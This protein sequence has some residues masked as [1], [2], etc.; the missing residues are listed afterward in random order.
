MN[1]R[2]VACGGSARCGPRRRRP[3]IPRGPPKLVEV[4]VRDA[5]TDADEDRT[6]A[7]RR[8][9]RRRQRRLEHRRSVPAPATGRAVGALARACAQEPTDEPNSRSDLVQLNLGLRG[10]GPVP[11]DQARGQP[12]AAGREV[13]RPR[14][15]H[16]D[17]AGGDLAPVLD[18]GRRSRRSSAC[19]RRSRP[20]PR[21]ARADPDASTTMQREPT[22]AP[23]ST[24]TGRPARAPRR[25]SRRRRTGGRPRRPGAHDPTVAHVHQGAGTDPGADVHVARHQDDAGREVRAVARGRGRHD[26]HAASPRP[27]LQ[28]QEVAVLERTDLGRLELRTRK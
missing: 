22:N 13:A 5:G 25:R 19:C 18:G 9:P 28:G 8:L 21:T 14:A 6:L 4:V 11:D 16:H 3:R 2:A 17:R 20:A 12:V 10:L 27:S 23:S 7:D 24:I 1:A 15:R 26:A